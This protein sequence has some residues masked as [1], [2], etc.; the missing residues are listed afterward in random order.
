VSIHQPQASFQLIISSHDNFEKETKDLRDV[1]QEWM[2]TVG[3]E[4][5]HQRASQNREQSF[6][7]GQEAD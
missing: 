1:A 2:D 5:A 7:D 4:R 6:Q 3:T